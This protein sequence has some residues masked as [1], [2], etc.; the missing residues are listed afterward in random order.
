[1]ANIQCKMCGGVNEIRDGVTSGVCQYCGGDFRKGL[2]GTK[3]T[4]CGKKKDY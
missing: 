2:F 4:R 1:M 3:C